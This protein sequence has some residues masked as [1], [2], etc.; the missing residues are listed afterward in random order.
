MAAQMK[1]PPGLDYA[2]ISG[3]NPNLSYGVVEAA[4]GDEPRR[5]LSDVLVRRLFPTERP[6]AGLPWENPTCEAWDVVL[7][8]E[9]CD[10][11]RDPQV[12]S[13]AYH[14]RAGEKIQ[15]LA[16]VVTLRFPEVEDPAVR[17][18]LHEAW[19]LSRGFAFRLTRK[20][21]V[22]SV[23]ILHVPA[24]SWGANGAHAHLVMPVRRIGSMVGFS[25]FV[26]Q[27]INP[28]EGRKLIDAEWSAHREGAGYAG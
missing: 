8:R 18:H 24:R 19:E 28:A 22:A 12:L 6:G 3:T 4:N 9:A 23:V 11:L 10:G 21:E 14:L 2:P 26:K 1:I 5:T 13:L 7:P 27:L 25:T 20:L 16:A 17:M 15:H